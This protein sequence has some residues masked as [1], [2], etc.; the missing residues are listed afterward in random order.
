MNRSIIIAIFLG[1]CIYQRISCAN[2]NQQCNVYEATNTDQGYASQDTPMDDEPLGTPVAVKPK[3]GKE[4]EVNVPQD[5][6]ADYAPAAKSKDDQN[7]GRSEKIVFGYT[8]E[9]YGASVAVA[10]QKLTQRFYGPMTDK[11]VL[12][13][14]A[15]FEQKPEII[16]DLEDFFEAEM[17]FVALRVNLGLD[18]TDE[19]QFDCDCSFKTQIFRH[20][21]NTDIL[22]LLFDFTYDQDPPFS[23]AAEIISDISYTLNN[24]MELYWRMKFNDGQNGSKL[25]NSMK[26]F[27]A[28]VNNI[29]LDVRGIVQNLKMKSDDDQ[30]YEFGNNEMIVKLQFDPTKQ[31]YYPQWVQEAPLYR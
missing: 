2:T 11:A 22:F 27:L 30:M 26:Q 23:T 8:R 16:S 12:S 9:N 20:E 5:T 24:S 15:T 13:M 18:G 25:K 28:N 21:K 31:I 3:D 1:I 19:L 17:R 29:T 7:A 10:L 14:S 6:A 4:T